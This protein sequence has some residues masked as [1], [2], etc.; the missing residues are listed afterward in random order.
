VIEN[1]IY[2]DSITN[3][4]IMIGKIRDR[5]VGL[6]SHLLTSEFIPSLLLYLSWVN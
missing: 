6:V 2:S 5:R 1:W 3:L 4:L